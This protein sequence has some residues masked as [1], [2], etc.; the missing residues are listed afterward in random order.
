MKREEA[1]NRL[2]DI[3]IEIRTYCDESKHMSE[4]DRQNMKAF[5]MAIKALEQ[6]PCEDAISR[7][8]VLMEID[9]YLCGVPFDEKGIDIVIKELPLVTPQ[10][11]KVGKWIKDKE[12]CLYNKC[13]ICCYGHCREDNYCP[14]CGAKM[15]E[16]EE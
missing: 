16:S 10:Q 4:T 15:T 7:E 1:I 8:A 5:D 3:I 13:S 2:R 14:N 9:K 6:E 11:K 12:N